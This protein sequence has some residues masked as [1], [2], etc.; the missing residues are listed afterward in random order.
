MSETP[1]G[2]YA[3]RL[4]FL[5]GWLT[6]RTLALLGM[7]KVKAVPMFAPELQSALTKGSTVARQKVIR[8]ERT[9]TSR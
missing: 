9:L 3:R 5:Y 6:G 1:T 7:D 8:L 2:V 4:W